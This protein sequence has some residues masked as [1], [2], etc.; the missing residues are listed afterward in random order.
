MRNQDALIDSTLQ[1][2]G[3]CTHYTHEHEGIP[4]NFHF[5]KGIA[6]LPT[7]IQNVYQDA[8]IVMFLDNTNRRKLLKTI[9]QYM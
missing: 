4:I 3:A 8:S 5:Y 7:P 2:I 9:D 1:I 6:N